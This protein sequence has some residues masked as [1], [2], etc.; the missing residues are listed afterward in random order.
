MTQE[1]LL[2]VQRYASLHHGHPVWLSFAKN[3]FQQA[4]VEIWL[5]HRKRLPCH[6]AFGLNLPRAAL[7]MDRIS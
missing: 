6:A 7:D 1:T 2:D 3:S 5:A 4:V